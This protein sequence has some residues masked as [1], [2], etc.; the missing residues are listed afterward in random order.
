MLLLGHQRRQA[1]AGQ[2]RLL[3]ADR[4]RRRA[5]VR[6]RQDP[7]LVLPSRGPPL[8]RGDPRLPSDR[9]PAAPV[10]RRRPAQR[11]PDRHHRALA[12]L[13]ASSTTRSRSTRHRC[14]PRSPACRSP[15]RSPACASRSSPV[16]ASTPTSGSRSRRSTQLEEAVFD[17][18]VAGRVVTDADGNEDVAIM[19]VEAE[20]TEGSWNLIKG[21]ATKPNEEVVAAGPRGL[22]AV[23]QAAR[24]GAERRSPHQAAEGDPGLPGLPALQPGDLRRRRRPSP[25]T[26]SSA[27]T[28]SPT[29]SS[30]R[31]PTTRSRTRV[32]AS[33][34]PP[35]SRPA[36]C[37]PPR[38]LEFSR[39]VQVGH[40]ERSCAA[41]S[42]PRASAST[43]VAWPTSVRSTPRC[44]SSRASTARRSSSAARPR[45]WVSPR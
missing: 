42:S 30:A 14:R 8:D 15:A 4:R 33:S 43:A 5:L 13:P 3:P 16:T 44:R 32:K 36:S 21:G 17:L 6:R 19:M 25:T 26:S 45:S 28:R 12:S 9:P 11:G 35:R 27:S 24:R 1:P 22:E 20:A 2:L 10:V 23:P 31:T 29:R 41:A 38:P 18:I 40:E 34:S 37:P 39:R 7:R